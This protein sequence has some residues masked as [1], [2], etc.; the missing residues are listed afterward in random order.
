MEEQADYTRQAS[1]WNTA[2]T[3]LNLGMSALTFGKNMEWF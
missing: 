2:S 3:F 1:N